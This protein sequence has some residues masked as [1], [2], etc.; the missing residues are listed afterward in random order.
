MPAPERLHRDHGVVRAAVVDDDHLVRLRAGLEVADD[1][2]QIPGQAARFVE[3][4]DDHRPARA[5]H[6]TPD[7]SRRRRRRAVPV[8]WAAGATPAATAGATLLLN[9]L[10]MMY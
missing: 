3:G 7:R 5:R 8:W 10:G 6:G 1:L 2:L 9:T 4:G